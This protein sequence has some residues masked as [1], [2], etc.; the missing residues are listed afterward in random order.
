MLKSDSPIIDFY[1]LDFEIDMNGKKMSWQGV[2]LLPFIDEIRLLEAMTPLYDQLTD[3]EERR[4]KWGSSLLFVSGTHAL[5]P[6]VESL[7][8]KRKP[9]D[10]SQHFVLKRRNMILTGMFL[11]PSTRTES[12]SWYGRK[13][14]S[15]PT[16]RPRGNIL[17][18]IGTVKDTRC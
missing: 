15:G 4:N 12:Q 1:P 13:C 8:S 6:F 2:A 9:K 3:D 10:V 16:V 18:S 17:L 11:A 14:A 5:F 7:Y